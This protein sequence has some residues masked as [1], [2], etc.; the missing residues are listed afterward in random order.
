MGRIIELLGMTAGIAGVLLCL[1]MGVVRLLG[2][3]FFMGY[4]TISLLTG[5][6]ALMVMGVL[7]KVNRLHQNINH[8]RNSV[9]NAGYRGSSSSHR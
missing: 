8:L 9:T 5:G 2:N 7:A 4:E 6:I 3:H 1:I